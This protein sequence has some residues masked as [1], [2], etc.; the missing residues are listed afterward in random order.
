MDG[1]VERTAAGPAFSLPSQKRTFLGNF[2]RASFSLRS[3]HIHPQKNDVWSCEM[4]YAILLCLLVYSY[5]TSTPISSV[6][7]SLIF[8]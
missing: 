3:I 4:L 8:S 6:T 1:V 5:L 7:L 2:E